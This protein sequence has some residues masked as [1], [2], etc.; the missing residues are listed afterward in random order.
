MVEKVG[1]DLRAGRRNKTGAGRPEVGPYPLAI[2]RETSAAILPEIARS[3]F[4]PCMEELTFC[5]AM[6]E[7]LPVPP[8]HDGAV[9][10]HSMPTPIHPR[11]R[12]SELELNLV[13]RG[14]GRYL[15]GDRSYELKPGAL[16]WLFPGQQHILLD[17]SPDYRMWIVVF[18]PRLLKRLCGDPSRRVLKAA[19][20]AGNFCRRLGDSV[21]RK[22]DRQFAD[23]KSRTH[24]ALHLNTALAAS[25]LDAW[26]AFQTADQPVLGADL[27][28]AVQKA[29]R[30]IQDAPEIDD[31]SDLARQA[32]LSRTRL[33]ELFKR[34]T[35]VALVDFRN[36]ARLE[37]FHSLLAT[38]PPAE[39]KLLPLALEAGFGSYQQFYRV[40][41]QRTGRNPATS[42]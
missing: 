26:A 30:L 36:R 20:P 6:R 37:K 3:V 17:M 39:R 35:G 42:G 1:P 7:K 16:I 29:A 24:D 9:W 34:Q 12:H 33:S 27:H 19:A 40:F 32:G 41:K 4:S 2:R 18:R 23:L 8:A 10:P 15:V 31:L 38:T 21:W 5:P 14:T 13:Q 22:L 25:L 11:H 28:P